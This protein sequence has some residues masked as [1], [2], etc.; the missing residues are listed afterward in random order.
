M[1]DF[2]DQLL[3]RHFAAA[4]AARPR[5]ALRFEALPDAA[6]PVAPEA[7]PSDASDTAPSF[8]SPISA[9]TSEPAL[10][11]AALPRPTSLSAPMPP[12]DRRF[13]RETA[14]DSVQKQEA[15]LTPSLKPEA[16]APADTFA[17]P[18]MERDSELSAPRETEQPMMLRVFKT[19]SPNEAPSIVEA[20][21]P[22][23]RFNNQAIEQSAEPPAL[24]LPLLLPPELPL[25]AEP[26]SAST[27]ATTVRVKIGRIELL[28]PPSPAPSSRPSVAR[29]AAAPLRPAR[30]LENYLSSPRQG[31][32]R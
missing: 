32:R 31:G 16:L 28:P 25:H 10:P 2:F 18:L 17:T 22:S 21:P 20:Q 29:P 4:P 26:S 8:H 30:S 1:S 19:V 15:F 9:Q 11:T 6:W 5:P 7:A 12:A 14:S 13:A 24:L 23:A 27:P 3:T